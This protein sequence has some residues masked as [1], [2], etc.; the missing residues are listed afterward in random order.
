MDMSTRQ[1]QS[2]LPTSFKYLHEKEQ[3]S[4]SPPSTYVD[5]R[6]PRVE[7]LLD[8]AIEGDDVA[9][10]RLLTSRVD[11]NAQDATEDTALHSACYSG[12][13]SS[14]SLLLQSKANP[15]IPNKYGDTALHAAS[16]NP[17]ECIEIIPILLKAR[18]TNP[19]PKFNPSTKGKANPNISPSLGRGGP[20]NVEPQGPPCHACT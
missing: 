20:I 15:N 19:N 5:E 18:F 2:T 11:P 13:D 17:E 6:D 3:S 16:S 9:I 10:R 4:V 8:A 14:V 12:S 7:A 1:P